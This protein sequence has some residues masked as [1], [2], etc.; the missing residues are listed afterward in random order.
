MVIG[1]GNDLKRNKRMMLSGWDVPLWKSYRN[2]EWLGKK[3]D[4]NN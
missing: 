1:L 2:W 3:G 4:N